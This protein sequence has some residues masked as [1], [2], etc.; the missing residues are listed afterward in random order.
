MIETGIKQAAQA[1]HK[2]GTSIRQ[3]GKLLSIDR[4]TVRRILNQNE[5]PKNNNKNKITIDEELLSE[6]YRKCDGY[7]ERV[8]EILT[9]D[10]KIKIAYSTLTA[11]IR[12]FELEENKK[13]RSGRVPDSPG[14]EFQHDTSPY[15]IEIGGVKTKIQG[16][17][18]YYRY[19]KV[20]YL[21]FYRSFTRF[22][23]KCFFHEAL[24]F[25]GHVPKTCIIDN[26]NLAVLRGTGDNAIFVPE[27]IS[28]AKQYGFKWK[29]H[30]IK[31][32][33]R[34]AGNERGF[35]TLETNF[36]PGRSF[37]SMEDLNAQALK[38]VKERE[39][40][41]TTKRKIIPCDA[42]AYEIPY[43]AKISS[44][45]PAPYLQHRRT[46][47]QYGYIAFDANYYWIPNEAKKEVIVL[48]YSRNICIYYNRNMIVEY[49]LP[50]EG[51]KNEKFTPE[52]I[53]ANQQPNN[54]KKSSGEHEKWLRGHKKEIVH[55]LDSA[56]KENN[57]CKR[58]HKFITG[59]YAL[60]RKLAPEIFISA[61][62]RAHKF[63][64]Y[65]L[66]T[67]EKICSLIIQNDNYECPEP[68]IDFG[69]EGREEYLEG[70]YS[71]EPTFE[72]YDKKYGGNET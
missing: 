50:S 48:Q 44:D 25:L 61:V 28:F 67:F 23:M 42:F 62:D 16:S 8:H 30:A 70:E 24:L 58:K 54:I 10:Y 7:G 1:L 5:V 4:K 20:R 56:I 72:T 60:A 46:I 18:T 49:G 51:I 12:K 27:M 47:D 22:N 39:A 55:F 3:I 26:T 66:E 34:K 69:Y 65:D 31:H 15:V 6:V 68:T 63:K 41:P 43:M 52:G 71:E 40:K 2:K 19:S 17:L 9:Q 35:W 11:L 45:L 53:T 21:V 36:F 64:V 57:G 13:Q 37:S 29:A 59:L 14:V 33:N 38:W 32:S